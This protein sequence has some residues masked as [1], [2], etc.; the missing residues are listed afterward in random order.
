M[1]F[2]AHEL[3]SE[4]FPVNVAGFILSIRFRQVGWEKPAEKETEFYTL[5]KYSSI[6]FISRISLNITFATS[7]FIPRY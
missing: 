5:I 7:K 1:C 4:P 2:T 3:P 6:I